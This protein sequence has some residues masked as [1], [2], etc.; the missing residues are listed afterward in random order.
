MFALG[1]G[2]LSLS[3][4]VNAVLGRLCGAALR[5]EIWGMSSIRVLRSCARCAFGANVDDGS[6]KEAILLFR[7]KEILFFFNV[8]VSQN[9]CFPTCG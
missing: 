9:D 8:A 1:V 7:P 4:D 3:G 2:K 6:V 5:T